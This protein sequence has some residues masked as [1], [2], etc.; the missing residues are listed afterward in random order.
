MNKSNE[1][2]IQAVYPL[3]G[4][5]TIPNETRTAFPA[6]LIISGTGKSDRDGNMKKMKMNIYKELAEFLTSKGFITLRYDKRGTHQS[7]GNFLEAGLNDLMDDAA[8]CVK[9]L[10]NHPKVDKEKVLIVGHSEGSLIAPAVYKKVP[11]SG[12]I[13]LAGAAEPSID[14]LPKQ[15]EM[16]YAEM[17]QTKGFKGWI[18]KVFKV[19]DKARKQNKKIFKKIADSD[20]AVMRVQGVRINAKWLRETLAYNVC[21]YL[22]EVTCPVLAITGEKD[23]QVPPDHVKLIAEMVK[24]E[25]EWHL[26]PNMNHILRKYAGQHTMLGLLKEYKTQLGQPIDSELFDKMGTWLQK[27]Y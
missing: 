9:F 4:T 12:L 1:V 6:A 2:T 10:Q 8:A 15:S 20:K 24:G 13:L 11:V 25:S 5:L 7:G 22:N 3:R 17:N 16:A 19:P 18:I 23:I 14:L 21:D 26:I 27:Y